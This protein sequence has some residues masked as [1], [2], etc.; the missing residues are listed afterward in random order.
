MTTLSDRIRQCRDGPVHNPYQGRD[1]RVVFVCSMGLLRSPTGARLYAHRYNTRSCGVWPDALIP[2]TT[3]LMEW[4]DEI[5]F[6]HPDTYDTAVKR[7]GD[8]LHL[9]ERA[10]TKVTILE[11]P[12]NHEHMAPELVK[13]F[14]EQYESL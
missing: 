7:F 3:D 2:L 11:I 4:A 14:S 12:D 8:T 9:Y 6:V 5:V 10:G 13:A 1:R